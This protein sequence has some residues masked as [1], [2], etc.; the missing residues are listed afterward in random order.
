M[1]D[2]ASLTFGAALADNLALDYLLGL[3]PV[4]AVSR[5][6]STAASLALATLMTLPPVA[7]CS[8]VLVQNVL[9]PLHLEYLRLL[10]LVIVCTAITQPAE[11]WLRRARPDLHQ[12]IGVFLPLLTANCLVLGAALLTVERAPG[13]LAAPVYGLGLAAGVGLV[14]VMLAGLRERLAAAPVPAAFRGVPITLL[15]LGFMSLGFLGLKGVW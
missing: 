4:V 8:A 2:L 6:L 12:R 11:R 3:C 13:A 5:R 7:L 14:L 1:A 9:Q 10:V 15:T